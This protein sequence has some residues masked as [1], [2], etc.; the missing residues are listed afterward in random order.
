MQIAFTLIEVRDVFA[1]R[2][3]KASFQYLHLKLRF[4]N[5]RI[6]PISSDKYFLIYDE[7]A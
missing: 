7:V 2:L 1:F 4:F 5:I 3:Y 6:Y